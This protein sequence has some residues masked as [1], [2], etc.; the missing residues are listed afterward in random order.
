M[1]SNQDAESSS[2][3]FRARLR[4]RL[5][6]SF[7]DEE[8]RTLCFDLGVEYENLPAQG[9]AGKARELTAHL[10]RTGDLPKL[11]EKC[12][13]LRPN[14]SWKDESQAVK[15]V[16]MTKRFS[17]R[18]IWLAAGLVVALLIGVAW[19]RPLL[20][21][22]VLRQS[23]PV[24]QTTGS[25]ATEA[26]KITPAV[27]PPGLTPALTM[28]L[29]TTPTWTSTPESI[30]P[31]ATSY[32]WPSEV[33]R[34]SKIL[35]AEFDERH[36]TRTME[37]A[38]R[39]E[40]DLKARLRE[41][42][43]TEVSVKVVSRPV[44]DENEAEA[45]AKEEKG[46][47]V[48]WGWYDDLG[49]SV[50]IFLTGDNQESRTSLATGELPFEYLGKPDADLSFIVRNV[51]PQNVSFLSLFVI[52]HLYYLA[53]Q[54]QAGHAAF[55]AAMSSIPDSVSLEN[56]ATLHF[57]RARQM[58]MIGTTPAANMDEQLEAVAEDSTAIV[59]EYAQAIRLAPYFAEAYNNLALA[60]AMRHDFLDKEVAFGCLK[61]T[62]QNLTS[63]D[64]DTLIQQAL[65]LRPDSA[66]IQYN[67]LAINWWSEGLLPESFTDELQSIV[68][69]DPTI[70]GPYVMLGLMSMKAANYKEAASQ[71][72]SVVTLVPGSAELRINLG[73]AYLLGGQYDKAKAEFLKASVLDGENAEAYLGLA[74]LSYHQEHPE[75]ALSYATS[76]AAR[77]AAEARI[78]ISR[79]Q[80]EGD[81][82]IR[83]LQTL[84]EVA[85]EDQSNELVKYLL[86]MMYKLTDNPDAGTKYQPS[87][88]DSSFL[89]FMPYMQAANF[90]SAVAWLNLIERCGHDETDTVIDWGTSANPCL[91]EDIKPRIEAVFDIF[92]GWLP[93]RLYYQ[94]EPPLGMAAC[95]YVFTYDQNRSSW[96]PDTTILYDLV[97]PARE[98]L[99]SRSLTRFDG[100]L[101]IRE[102]E[103]ETSY[104]DLIFVVVTDGAGQEIK[105][106]PQHPMLQMADQQYFVLNYG[107]EILL[108]FDR[109]REIEA[110]KEFRVVAQGYYI[111]LQDRRR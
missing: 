54:Y 18:W 85:S 61:D 65:K 15:T 69:T 29:S 35:I 55:D 14:V 107:E 105:L 42:G 109:Y 10:D 4:Q 93:Y 16:G 52:G 74:N 92:Q 66:L 48:I 8:L 56:E 97:G 98:T 106:S 3:D 78:L 21:R 101:L 53:N 34:P 43:L 39:L 82:L 68:R 96:Q 86:W 59:C 24:A 49:I 47:A 102:V 46:E 51:L 31:T 110:P 77:G 30:T 41:F 2:T 45:L 67:R 75:E 80:F 100:R 11:I 5:V 28:V 73:Q 111:S 95:P 44:T 84:E 91:P 83:S 104:I 25:P 40:A 63:C 12:H 60:C 87:D 33:K 26:S 89:L 62:G 99:Q 76:A 88:I 36:A 81:Q 108:T 17:R 9:K 64:E 32:V 23:T 90:T 50:Q 38:R 7:S 94:K 1:T 6:D 22:L 71:F 72:E 20:S 27:P 58:E 57:F 70:P 79:L 19:V 103:P 37:V 13:R